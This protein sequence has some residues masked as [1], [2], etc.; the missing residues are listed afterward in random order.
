MARAGKVQRVR[1]NFV[2]IV[3]E[4]RPGCLPQN[5]TIVAKET[6]SYF[7]KEGITKFSATGGGEF[8]QVERFNLYEYVMTHDT[9]LTKADPMK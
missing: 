5:E 6:A 3:N 8:I 1:R 4:Y 7:R 2:I 9:S